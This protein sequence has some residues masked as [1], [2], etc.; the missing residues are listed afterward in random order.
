VY[1][2]T[3]HAKRKDIIYLHFSAEEAIKTGYR[4]A[5]SSHIYPDYYKLCL[6]Q[7]IN[8]DRMIF[9]DVTIEKEK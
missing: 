8:Q 6:D 7:L 1:K 3:H 9:I 4:I 5:E 2:I